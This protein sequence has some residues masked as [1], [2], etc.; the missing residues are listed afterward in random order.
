MF[1][2]IAILTY[3]VHDGCSLICIDGYKAESPVQL[4]A[5]FKTEVS[6]IS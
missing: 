4:M 1:S 5:Y 2:K 6:Y 3:E